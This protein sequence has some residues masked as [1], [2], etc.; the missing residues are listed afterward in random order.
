MKDTITIDFDKILLFFKDTFIKVFKKNDI[1]QDI[2]KSER[3]INSKYQFQKINND[4]AILNTDTNKY[5]DLSNCS[6]EWLK[7]SAYFDD[8]LG[9]KKDIVKCFNKHEPIII[10]IK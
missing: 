7:N 4:Y 9:T 5:V 3:Y 6:S 10:D 2:M 1:L 8:C